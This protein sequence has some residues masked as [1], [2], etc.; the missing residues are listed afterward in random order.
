MY[1]VPATEQEIESRYKFYSDL[2]SFVYDGRTFKC[3]QTREG[4]F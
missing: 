4:L 3:I 1:D 2:F